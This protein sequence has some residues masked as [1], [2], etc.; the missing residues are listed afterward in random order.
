VTECYRCGQEGHRAAQCDWKPPAKTGRQPLPVPPPRPAHEIADARAW[1]EKI[2]R[3][4]GWEK[5]DD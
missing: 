1:A 5:T 2:R 4:F 3:Q